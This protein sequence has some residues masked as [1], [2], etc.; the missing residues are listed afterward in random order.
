MTGV[1]QSGLTPELSVTDFARSLRFYRDILGFTV[2]YDRPEAGFGFLVYEG[3]NLW[4][5]QIG[6]G[7]TWATAPLDPPLGRGVNFERAVSSLDPILKRL[8]A[9]KI[10]LYLEPETKSYRVAGVDV[11]QRQFC[12]QDPDGYLLRFA[13]IA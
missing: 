13:E 6:L 10:P 5:D 8:G 11:A 12:V 7:R 3:C 4:L 9:A 1:L 2:A